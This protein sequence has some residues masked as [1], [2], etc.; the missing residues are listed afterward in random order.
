M[1]CEPR[2]FDGERKLLVIVTLPLF[3]PAIENAIAA[4]FRFAIG[5]AFVPFEE[6]SAFADPTPP[7]ENRM[8]LVFIFAAALAPA[9]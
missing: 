7:I 6:M 1:P 2:M 9:M 8:A 3:D 5:E 4:P